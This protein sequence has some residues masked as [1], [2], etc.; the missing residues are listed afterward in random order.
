M[1]SNLA[2]PCRVGLAIV[3][4]I[5]GLPLHA[6]PIAAS[7]NVTTVAADPD[8]LG[9]ER[10]FSAWMEGQIAYRGLPGIEVGVVSD[11]QLVW[12][13][14]FGF[15]NIKA[16]VPMTATTKFRMA[17]NSKLFTAIAIM[18]LREQGKLGLDDPVVK[19]LPWF[20][21]KSAGDDDG[22][23]IIEQLLSHSLPIQLPQ[24]IGASD[25]LF[26]ALDDSSQSSVIDLH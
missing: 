11:Q 24:D 18:R 26:A 7:D 13:K 20:K 6:Q 1:L 9:E 19:Y 5:L 10:L 4:G 2:L 12:S 25:T 3:V 15:A 17:S 14:G 8:V 16:K 22:P 23:I 21:A